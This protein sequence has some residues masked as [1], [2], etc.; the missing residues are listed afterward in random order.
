MTIEAFGI[1]VQPIYDWVILGKSVHRPDLDEK[2]IIFMRAR[3]YTRLENISLKYTNADEKQI[4]VNAADN[5]SPETVKI[6]IGFLYLQSIKY[7]YSKS[8]RDR[9]KER[10][11]LDNLNC[12]N[13]MPELID[14]R[15]REWIFDNLEDAIK[16]IKK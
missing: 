9:L 7:D 8:S 6:K 16:A 2:T 3:R 15:T 1:D 11:G 13:Y 14:G 5:T 4:V 10:L 12:S